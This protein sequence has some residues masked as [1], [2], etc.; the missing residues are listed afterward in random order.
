M[1]VT[2]MSCAFATHNSPDLFP[3]NGFIQTEVSLFRQLYTESLYQLY[4]SPDGFLNVS[5]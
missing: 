4:V 1:H 2:V 3:N 5:S